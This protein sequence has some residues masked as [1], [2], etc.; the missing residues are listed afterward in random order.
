[1]VVSL[2]PVSQQVIV[3]TGAT[4]G[5]GLATAM[6]A[7]AQ[8][9]RVVLAARNESALQQ[10]VQRITEDG[11]QAIHVVADVSKPEDVQT[12]SDAAIRTFG[13]FDTWVN[14]AGISVFGRLDEVT[15]ED[16]RRIFDVNFWGVVYGTRV[17]AALLKS[18]GGAIINLGSLASDVALPRQ[19]MY[20][21]SKHAIKG[22]T[23]GFRM[24]MDEVGAPV[25]V[26]L[27]KPASINTPFPAHAKN[28]MAEEPKL[29]PPIYSPDDVADAILYAAAHGGRDYYIGSGARIGSAVNRVA[30]HL[31]DW[32][33]ARMVPGASH[34]RETAQTPR[35]GTLFKPGEDG[36]VHGSSPHMVRHSVY[37]KASLHPIASAALLTVAGLAGAALL[38]PRALPMR[39]GNGYRMRLG[40]W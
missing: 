11:G 24:E 18:K 15:D 34:H 16:H 19:G 25:S 26:T 7:A 12:I 35:E 20:A 14:N 31:V 37:T 13:T 21:A 17:A 10:A 29:P 9:A 4:S 3:I 2:K 30:P 22:F 23:D 1:M 5:I 36:A 27:I 8:G 38:R 6:R 39:R 33:S 40:N 32:I 28:Y